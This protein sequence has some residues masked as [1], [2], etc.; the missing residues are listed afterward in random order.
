MEETLENDFVALKSGRRQQR[1]SC[2]AAICGKQLL[3]P[4]TEDGSCH[5]E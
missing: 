2:I 4:F 1:V 5:R 3:A